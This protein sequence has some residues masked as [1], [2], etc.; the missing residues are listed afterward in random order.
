VHLK[1]SQIGRKVGYCDG[2][3]RGAYGLSSIE[4]TLCQRLPTA[5]ALPRAGAV[6]VRLI[7]QARVQ[8]LQPFFIVCAARSRTHRSRPRGWHRRSVMGA[9]APAASDACAGHQRRGA[10]YGRRTQAINRLLPLLRELLHHGWKLQSPSRGMSAQVGPG[11][12][13]ISLG[14]RTV[15]GWLVA[16]EHLKQLLAQATCEHSIFRER[17]W[18]ERFA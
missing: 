15:S 11:F 6:P 2:N 18:S 3:W 10:R 17:Q 14:S 8:V 16:T 1:A 13:V 4:P 5:S 12:N 9:P 7:Q